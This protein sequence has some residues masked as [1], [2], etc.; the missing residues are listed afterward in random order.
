MQLTALRGRSTPAASGLA[1]LAESCYSDAS[2]RTNGSDEPLRRDRRRRCDRRRRLLRPRLV[3]KRWFGSRLDRNREMRAMHGNGTRKR[4]CQTK[5][6]M[7]RQLEARKKQRLDALAQRKMQWHL[8]NGIFQNITRERAIG[9]HCQQIDRLLRCKQVRK[10]IDGL[11]DLCGHRKLE[12]E[13]QM[14]GMLHAWLV[15]DEANSAA[16]PAASAAAAAKSGVEPLGEIVP[17]ERIK[18]KQLSMES[19]AAPAKM[20]HLSVATSCVWYDIAKDNCVPD[21]ENEYDADWTTFDEVAALESACEERVTTE[22]KPNAWET[23]EPSGAIEV[24]WADVVDDAPDLRRT[25]SDEADLPFTAGSGDVPEIVNEYDAGWTTSGEVAASES[26]CEERA[27]T[28]LEPKAKETREPSEAIEVIWADV[29]DYAPDPRRTGS[30]VA[31]LPF[32]TG[33]GGGPGKEPLA[34]RMTWSEKRK[35]KKW[36][37]PV[38][39]GAR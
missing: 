6:K 16:E 17:Q 1:S 7:R 9:I 32:T 3:Q 38:F 33:S 34:F 4:P 18:R 36:R 39:A 23:G 12:Y 2:Y 8:Y 20:P 28:A 27:T 25:G 22:L 37:N 15:A 21:I 10:H 30:D 11:L 24:T 14:A 13:D 26:A 29:E 5:S 31:D 19:D 35:E